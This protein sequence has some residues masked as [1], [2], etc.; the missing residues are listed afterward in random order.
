MRIAVAREIDAGENRVAATPEQ[1][2]KM[3]ALGADVAVEPNAGTKSGIHDAEF[4]AAGAI[5]TNEPIK[6]ADVVL[7]VRRPAASELTRYKKGALDIAMM[8]PYGEDA[9]LK[10]IAHAGI[11]PVA[12]TL[13]PPT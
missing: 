3:K 10:A 6:D 9:A 4:A 8:D 12:L 1:V 11:I 13:F 7:K 5:V 2:K